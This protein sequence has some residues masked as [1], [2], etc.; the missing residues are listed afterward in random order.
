[1]QPVIN[2]ISSFRLED[3]ALASPEKSLLSNS[4]T[5]TTY[6]IA[7]GYTVVQYGRSCGGTLR[8]QIA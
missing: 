5:E 7:L 4:D 2:S 6:T 1:M 8:N 3:P